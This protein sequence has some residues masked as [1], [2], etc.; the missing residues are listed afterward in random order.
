MR[1][2][3]F[4]LFAAVAAPLVWSSA[5]QAQSID[6]D[7]VERTMRIGET[8]TI[9]KTITVG[10]FGATTVDI[11]FLSDRTGSMFGTIGDAQ[12]GAS[13]ILGGLPSTYRFGAGSYVEDPSEGF[14]TGGSSYTED[15]ALGTAAAAQAGIDSWAAGGGGDRD[16]ANLYALKQVAETAGWRAEAQRLVVWFGDEPGHTE[17]TTLDESIAALLAEDVTVIAFNNGS[18]GF[19]IDNSESGGDPRNQ[20]STIVAATGGSLTNNFTA[21][22]VDF[23][24][25]V[26]DAIDDATS[27]LDLNFASTFTGTGLDIS[28]VCTDPLGCTGVGSGESRTFELRITALE[29]GVYDFDV[30]AR[31]VD[32]VERDLITVVGVPEPGSLLLFGTG[33][34]GFGF[35][36]RRRKDEEVA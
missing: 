24:T 7:F 30:F 29:A 4:A 19:G 26:S 23:V 1:R 16:E 36:A 3:R 12:A 32:A 8:I 25:T 20:A 9:D 14:I 31:G 21:P 15:A 33:L 18:A 5:L 28:F 11:F 10:D 35:A 13:T 27:T 6:P 2:S 34:L 17:T 22:G